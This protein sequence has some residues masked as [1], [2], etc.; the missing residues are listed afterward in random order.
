MHP[1]QIL[2]SINAAQLGTYC[3]LANLRRNL[4]KGGV[5][6][7]ILDASFHFKLYISEADPEAIQILVNNDTPTSAQDSTNLAP[8][9]TSDAA[10]PQ[11]TRVPEPPTA[12][13]I[14][15]S[16]HNENVYKYANY[17]NHMVGHTSKAVEYRGQFEDICSPN[18]GQD[19]YFNNSNNRTE[20]GRDGQFLRNAK[21]TIQLSNLPEAATHAD[22][23]DAVKGGMLLDVFLRSQDRAASISFLDGNAAN[24]F[25]RYA[26]RNDLY[27]RGKRV[28]IS[29]SD[30]HFTL[31]NHVAHKIGMGATRNIVIRSAGTRHTDE[32]IREDLEHIH[33]LVIISVKF[34][35]R[36]AHVSTNSVHNAMFARTCMMSRSK[37]KGCKIEWDIDE[38]AAPIPVLKPRP[39]QKENSAPKPRAPINRFALL[40]MDGATESSTD[41]DSMLGM[42]SFQS[43]LVSGLNG[44]AV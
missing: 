31:A 41:E 40:N 13:G 17:G 33:N 12:Y 8:G 42:D 24:D 30:R 11:L 3:A 9:G 6:K 2:G 27:I 26:K 28:T 10:S 22:V 36:D 35:D 23:T 19:G 15:P 25:F 5:S 38:C 1:R 39:I 20:V 7:D 21:R 4:Y 32:S 37:Y 43:D 16:Y 34:V 14:S 18:E 44:V 29:W